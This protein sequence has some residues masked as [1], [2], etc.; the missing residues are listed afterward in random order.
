MFLFSASASLASGCPAHIKLESS[1]STS[2]PQNINLN[3][4]FDILNT[5]DDPFV[6][7]ST[8]E[9]I[10]IVQLIVHYQQPVLQALRVMTG[11]HRYMSARDSNEVLKNAD[12]LRSE[13]LAHKC[14]EACL[15]L[16]S[17]ARL[18]GLNPPLLTSNETKQHLFF[19]RS[20][21]K[22]L[23]LKDNSRKV[24]RLSVESTASS[25]HFPI[26]LSQSDKDDI[27]TEFCEATNNSALRRREFS[28]CGKLEAIACTKLRAI[29][30]LDISLLDTAVAELR[31]SSRQP[32][33]ETFHQRTL[34]N[35]SYVLCYL[36]DSAVKKQSFTSIPLRS[37]AN[38]L[39]IGQIPEELKDLTF[40]EEQCIA[41]ARA[42]KCMYKLTLGPT[43]Q[44]AARGNVC[45]LPQDTAS[46]LP[47]MPVP[48]FQLR[49]EICVILISSPDTEVTYDM[50][51]RSPLLVRRHK[52]QTALFWLIKNNP[53][54]MD[55]NKNAI[56]ENLPA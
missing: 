41:R 44:L 7:I 56:I 36:C 40:L 10:A 19:S 4:N 17:E 45:I 38:G 6:R 11:R 54:Y 49:E 13:F 52:V 18:G 35:N 12:T 39:W 43:G 27:V 1:G 29:K 31:L 37:Y 5:N 33:I 15:I 16:R 9:K 26:L 24:P 34:I 32:R 20:K 30:E 14:S 2:H 42:T 25:T 46:V 22:S 53:L 47:A 8:N 50:L 55:L 51:R 48:L 23:H 3:D 28:F 21:Q